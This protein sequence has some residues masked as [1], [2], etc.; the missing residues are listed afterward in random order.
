[1][2]AFTVAVALA[3]LLAVAVA[4]PEERIVK[5]HACVAQG[6]C[7][8]HDYARVA[9]ADTTK[10]RTITLWTTQ[11][12]F[13]ASCGSALHEV[14]D[15][16]SP[17]FG[18]HVSFEAMKE[19]VYDAK[20]LETIHAFLDKHGVAQ[21]ARVVS[22]N[23][24]WVEVTADVATIEKMFNAEFHVFASA[25]RKT[26]ITR[27]FA[28]TIPAELSEAVHV[29]NGISNFP[30][31]RKKT[32]ILAVE[33]K[34]S[35]EQGAGG[36]YPQLIFKTYRLPNETDATSKADMGVFEALGQS[37]S[38]DDLAAFQQQYNLP[39]QKIAKIVG[40]NDPSSCSDDPNNCVEATLDVEYIMAMAQGAP[41]TYW[42]IADENGDIFL[43]WAK[44]V[45]K[46]ATPAQVFSISYGGPEHLQDQGDMQQ[47]S[48]EVCKMGLRGMTV[49]VASGDD[50]VA[51]YEARGDKSK[52]GFFPE[53]PANVPYVTT[54]GATMGPAL[55][56]PRDEMV[57]MSN[58]GS[59]ITSG[60]GFSLVFPQPSWQTQAVQTYL[61]TGPNIPPKNMYGT[62]RAYPDVASLGNAYNI[63]VGG[64]WFQVSGTSAASPVFCGMIAL[65]NGNREAAGKSS[66]GYL[67]P[68][69]YKVDKSVYNDVTDGINNC[70][71]GGQSA[72]TCCKYGFTATKG[73]DPATGWGSLDYPLFAQAVGNLP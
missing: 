21:N 67:N 40:P 28:H 53:Y 60:G 2:K 10:T 8:L 48:V 42:S 52:C 68:I 39:R 43:E 6:S 33:A 38:D 18:Q 37:Y 30:M 12:N 25:E 14:S 16:D 23:G 57:C 51:G 17:K 13:A 69:L 3:A 7:G 65:I 41:M 36:M 34:R 5:A 31:Y 58:K 4:V 24:E 71:A 45:A 54:V 72:P 62:G 15:P 20:A 63:V 27:S 46:V 47:F 64:Q 11:N 44:A 9:R 35:T 32:N 50:G 56:P 70:C 49:F 73:W 59:I 19:L 22:P 66:I 61:S 55:N 26:K 1:M 29:V